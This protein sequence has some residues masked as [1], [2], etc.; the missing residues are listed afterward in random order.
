VLQNKQFTKVTWNDG[1]RLTNIDSPN[2]QYFYTYLT[3]CTFSFLT[4]MGLLP[5]S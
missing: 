3:F 4:E 5:L 2:C 1:V